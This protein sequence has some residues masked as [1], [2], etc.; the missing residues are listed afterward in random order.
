LARHL[1]AERGVKRLLLLSRRTPEKGLIKDLAKLGA[2]VDTA[3]CDVSDRAGLEQALAA[4]SPKH[5]LT[6]VIH[7]A[8]AL[9]DGVIEAQTPE[10]LDTVLKPKADAAWHLHELTKNSDLAAFVLYSSAAGVLGAA[11]QGN[12]AAANAFLDALAEQRQAEGLPA[13]SLAWGLWEQTSGL[14]ATLTDTDHH[15]IRRSGQRMITA[16]HGIRLYDT[17]THHGHP[18]LIAAPT[19]P[20]LG[21]EVPA[22]L[23]GL[24]TAR[25]PQNPAGAADRSV[26]ALKSRLIGRTAAEQHRLM[27]AFV[28]GNVASVLGHG[29]A[30]AI[31]ADKPFKDLGMDSLTSVELRNSLA[32]ATELRL[33]A[34]I[35]FD[36][37]TA[38]ALAAHLLVKL[39]LPAASQP[40]AEPVADRAP[41]NEPIA[42]V[43]MACR[44][45]GGVTSP[46]GLWRLV[47]SGS[48]AISAFPGDRGWDVANLYSPDPDAPGKSYSVQGGFL[49]GA[50]AFDASFFG[51][52]PREALGMDP[53]QR[54]LLETAWE[55]VERARIDPRSLRGRDV[56]VYV[57]GA[58]QGYG[59][60][61]AEAQRDNLITGGSISLLSGRLSYALGL[62]GPG[63]TVDT[64]CSSSL[65][66]LHLA[67]QALRQGE[68]SLALVSGVSVM[69]TPDVFVEFSRQRGLASDGRCKSFAASADGTSWS[70]GVGVLVLERLSEAHRLGHQ[71]LAVVRGTAVNSDGASNG[72]T[73]PNGAAQQ[74][75]IRQALANA[76]LG[77]ADVDAV[78]A[79]GTGTT[80]G[81]PIEAEAILATYGKDRSTPV[82]L[83]SLKSNIG[84]TMAASGVLGVI[85]MVEAMRH[86]VLP[87]TLHVDEP[88]PHVDWAAGEVALLTENQP[89]PGDVRPRRA[90]VSSFG[91]SG[92]NAHVVL[93]QYEA[94]AAPVTAKES[95]PLPW[96]LSA[97][98]PKALRQ[99]AGQLAAALAEDSTW[100][101]LDVAYSLATTRS[102]FAHRAVVVGAD[103]EDFLRT[104]GKLADGAGWPGLMTGTAK[105][106]RVAFLFDGQGTQRLTMGQ[107]LYESFPAF[108]RAWDTVSAEFGKH[109]D[110]PLA[111][112]YFDGVGGAAAT[113]N[114]VDDPLYAQAG[115]FAV[116]VALV[117]LLAEWGVRPDVVTGHSIGEAAAAYTA[118]MLS[119]SDV[120]TLIVARG[121]AL[122]AAPPGAM[123]A[124]RAGEQEVRDF[125]DDTGAA[126]DLAAVNG[127]AAV[128]VSGAPDAVTDF[129]SAWTAS[130]RDARRLKVRRAFHSRHVEGVLDDFRTALES[131]SFRTPLL[132][133][134]ST[135][136]G[137]LIDPAEMGTP[138][139]WL[140]QVRQPVRFQDA[141][142]ELA[143][144]G[145]GTF[146]E[147]GPSGTL[148]SAGMECLDGDAT[149]HALL[150]PRS[151]EDVGV[152]TALAELHAGGTAVDWATVLAGGRPMDLPVYPFQH[153]SYWLASAAPEPATETV[154]DDEP[155]QTDEPRTMLELVHLEVAGVLGIT[156]PDTILD[157]ASFLE[158]GFDSLSGVR[159]RNRLA[160]A[161][162]L[163]LPPTLLFDHVTP[164]ALA[165][166]LDALLDVD[167]DA[168]GVLDLL[169]EVDELDEEAI[170]MSAAE[171]RAISDL[172]AKLSEKWKVKG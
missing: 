63:L 154:A 48:D 1:V 64:A 116:E 135:V 8:G 59:L 162:G 27:L 67:A 136:T 42:I 37:P 86:G 166:E 114:L 147:V 84:H 170:A 160:Q 2:Q 33:P 85:K 69:P 29:S 20:G 107:G 13:L 111:D 35:V 18:L 128:V 79:H 38:D 46:E 40:P 121:A 168:A 108:T 28:L 51:I 77:T 31:A 47:E 131:L 80:L 10:R 139:Y 32:K 45:P 97:Q 92:T 148:A 134:V 172:L 93:E 14:T 124:L 82:W 39:G 105:T 21:T 68:C 53:Q 99:R 41:V 56:G 123:L 155:P 74:R 125:L 52:S 119:L 65:V 118:G 30:D 109:L 144:Q 72:L 58:A 102:D 9:D 126:L 3:R 142:Q 115:I 95:G 60:G 7:T 87:R 73:A 103:R 17:A 22:L 156:D 120:T 141:V 159:L 23:R 140:D 70:E 130:G 157:D 6:A 91:L 96:V 145:V 78:E 62:E 169:E 164:A 50:A 158:L 88:S 146:V 143:G 15:R 94:P 24:A 129:A 132:P 138:E 110:H 76:G 133:V 81:D 106:R 89:W 26:H 54:L 151:A 153:Q 5:P 4:V 122:R 43:S 113:A 100:H 117:E 75:V 152:L 55:A 57:G 101:P 98:N 36:H 149:F 167:V 165:T 71:V 66:A 137:R 163:T 11:G 12:Y 83:G 16:E 25:R 127:P 150:R 90:G 34:T 44:V 161:T 49:D 19:R 171:H 104:L 112:V 61:A